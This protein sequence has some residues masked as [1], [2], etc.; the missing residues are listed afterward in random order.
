MAT[1]I[2]CVW[3]CA[4]T[5]DAVRL[6]LIRFRVDNGQLVVVEMLRWLQLI[7]V[8]DWHQLDQM[9][10]GAFGRNVSNDLMSATRLAGQMVQ[11]K[12]CVGRQ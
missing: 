1:R 7:V 9:N 3:W 2:V 12:V 4:L 10:G 5:A 6:L 8:D 11:A